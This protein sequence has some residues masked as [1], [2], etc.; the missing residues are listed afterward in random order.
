MRDNNQWTGSVWASPSVM[1]LIF[2]SGNQYI[3][4]DS[5][6]GLQ[7]VDSVPLRNVVSQIPTTYLFFFGPPMASSSLWQTEQRFS[8]LLEDFY[9]YLHIFFQS[10]M[11]LIFQ[12]NGRDSLLS[13]FVLRVTCWCCSS[14]RAPFFLVIVSSCGISPC[15]IQFV[16]RCLPFPQISHFQGWVWVARHG[17]CTFSPSS[18]ISL[19]G[20]IGVLFRKE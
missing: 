18:L 4:L 7:I 14:S 6:S 3:S 12:S 20:K 2:A 11:K 13:F 9:R 10:N 19:N 8:L 17:P 16:E 1:S 15:S 5:L